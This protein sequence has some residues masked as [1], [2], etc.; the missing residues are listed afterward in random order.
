MLLLLGQERAKFMDTYEFDTK[1]M[2][3]FYDMINDSL[4]LLIYFLRF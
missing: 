4:N 2:E 3:M 1:T